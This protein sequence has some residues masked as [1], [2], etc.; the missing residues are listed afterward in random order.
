[1]KPYKSIYKEAH[2]FKIDSKN[3]FKVDNESL[4]K[5][6]EKEIDDKLK[7]LEKE[8]H[9]TLPVYFTMKFSYKSIANSIGI[10]KDNLNYAQYKDMFSN[11]NIGKVESYLFNVYLKAGWNDIDIKIYEDSLKNI[12]YMN[13]SVSLGQ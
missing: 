2:F 6:L 4:S 12:P 5:F 8:N 13:I 7:E 9:S 11:I 10:N 3:S 1:M